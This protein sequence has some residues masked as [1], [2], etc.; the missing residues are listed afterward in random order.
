[1]NGTVKK[2]LVI[3]V[4]PTRFA[5][6]THDSDLAGAFRRAAALGYDGVELAVRDPA[7]LDPAALRRAAEAEGIAIPALGTGQAFVEEGLSLTDPEA[8]VRQAATERLKHQLDFAAALGAMVIVGLI[9]GRGTDDPE[10]DH[11]FLID[12]LA[13][14]SSAAADR[15][16]TILLEPINRYETRLV[17][18]VDDG[19]AL[20]A[21]LPGQSVRLLLDTFHMN[22]E[23][24]FLSG[25]FVR[26]AAVTG[27]VHWADSNRHYP[28]AGHIPFAELA[29][30]LDATGY[31]GYV[32]MEMLPWPDPERAAA[33][34]MQ[35]LNRLFPTSNSLK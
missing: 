4:S 31:A 15:G 9:R 21:E 10:R 20:L 24:P 32:S 8:T 18:T 19:L 23:E 28:G 5:A 7:G 22:I 33:A 26:A 34:A 30:V 27:H 16:V 17:N 2:G 12:G 29:A 25:S 6:V 14:L 11:A 1:V 3:S 13:D 35:T